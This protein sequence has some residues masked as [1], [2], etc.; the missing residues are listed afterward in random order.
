MASSQEKYQL[1]L[2]AREAAADKIKK[3]NK[4]VNDLGGPA[5]VKSQKEIKRLERNLKTLNTTTAKS[6][7]IF[8]RFTKGIAIGTIAAAAAMKAFGML[9][10]FLKG[11]FEAALHHEK[12]WND[13]AASLD[14]HRTSVDTNVESIKK[15][16]DSMQT[17]S[18]ISDELVGTAFQRLHDSNISVADSMDLTRA[19]MDLAVAKGMDVVMVAD[20]MGKSINS[21]TNALS[22]YGITIDKTLPKQDQ[23]AQLQKQVNELFGGAA[24]ARMLT[25]AGRLDL[26]AQRMGDL[27][28]AIGGVVAQSPAFTWMLDLIS[29]A[30][31]YWGA[32]GADTNID[33]VE[34]QIKSITEELQKQEKIA[35]EYSELPIYKKAISSGGYAAERVEEL[36]KQ[37]ID[38][39]FQ[40]QIMSDQAIKNIK[41]EKAERE[42]LNREMFVAITKIKLPDPATDEDL[43]A[44]AAQ[45]QERL[46]QV[47]S[48][49]ITEPFI[50]VE[51]IFPDPADTEA[52]AATINAQIKG[53]INA[54]IIKR[55]QGQFTAAF[56][57]IGRR[58]V[59]NLA[60]TIATGR[61]KISDVFKGMYEDF[62]AF[63]IQQALA[64]IANM[65]VP[66]LGAILGGIF[67]TPKYD[68]LAMEQG[69]H[70]AHYFTQ[71]VFDKMRTGSEFMR[72]IVPSAANMAMPSMAD[73]SSSASAGNTINV[74]F[75]GN[76]L[77]SEFIED[78]VAPT[79]RKLA[80]NGK[81]DLALNP[82][83]ITGGRNVRVY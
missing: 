51:A 27:Q 12:V 46:T 67:D 64:S 66:G 71:G 10:R 62:M 1:V 7:P 8:S 42:A 50:P 13:V 28:E 76:V 82:E 25:T 55:Q 40:Q 23:M 18:G 39:Q 5:M 38:L 53:Q 49:T 22:R 20:L 56:G 35:R 68:R 15:F 83:N 11:T 54:D 14:R 79:L 26:M 60:R 77:S 44:E 81:S 43:A 75:S 31:Q 80:T 32:F 57:D 4:Q 41:R 69:Q 29:D 48:G 65:F 24:A 61:G 78:Q 47:L 37:L 70:F 63:F 9:T 72:G 36:R 21:S 52:A 74:T 6:K 2:E 16:A 33:I 73:P 59:Q 45:F 3:L 30:A 34:A 58:G 19:S 17:L